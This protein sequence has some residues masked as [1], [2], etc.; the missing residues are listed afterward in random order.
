MA[1]N[2]NS[3]DKSKVKGLLETRTSRPIC[4][5]NETLSPKQPIKQVGHAGTQHTSVIQHIEGGG[6]R[7]RCSGPAWTIQNQN[8]K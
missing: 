8:K 6:K 3:T 7:I 2:F 4:T 5:T 1:G